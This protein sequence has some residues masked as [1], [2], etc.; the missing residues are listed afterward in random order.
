MA[1][2][3]YQDAVDLYYEGRRQ[4]TA[5]NW[6][7]VQSDHFQVHNLNPMWSGLGS[8][9]DLSRIQGKPDGQPFPD[10]KGPYSEFEFKVRADIASLLPAG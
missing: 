7:S 2:V 3:V 10:I 8:L 6:T 5:G 9:D 1:P 4:T